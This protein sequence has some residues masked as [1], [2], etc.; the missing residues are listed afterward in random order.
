MIPKIKKNQ[1]L[2]V[3]LDKDLI[4]VVKIV[5]YP[6]IHSKKNIIIIIFF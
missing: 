4:F 5:I 3:K 2:K 6:I 1:Y